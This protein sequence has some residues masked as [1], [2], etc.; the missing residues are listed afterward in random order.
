MIHGCTTNDDQN[1][2]KINFSKVIGNFNGFSKLCDK[3]PLQQ[4]TS[5]SSPENN[6]LKVILYD[7]NNIIVQDGK[8]AFGEV[9]MFFKGS[10]TVNGIRFLKFETQDTIKQYHLNFNENTS[11]LTLEHKTGLDML[12]STLIFE[13]TK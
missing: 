6:F 2:V 13:G 12:M 7:Q 9:K 1:V 3:K 5:C 11:V 8:N 10:E 4:D